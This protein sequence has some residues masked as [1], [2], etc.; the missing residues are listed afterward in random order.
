MLP[1][2]SFFDKLATAA[3]G[4][5]MSRFRQKIEIENKLDDGF[6]PVTAADKS[7][8]RA[9]RAVIEQTYPDHGILG[10]EE[11][12]KNLD[13]EFVW[14]IDPI[15]G[16]RAFITGLP[17]WGTLIG[18][19]QNGRAVMGMMDQPFTGERFLS[20][21]QSSFM[22][23]RGGEPQVL[24]TSNV[25]DL[26]KASMF[27]TTPELHTGDNS[28]RYFALENEIN[29]PRYGVDCYAYGMLAMGHADLVCES[30]LKPY[31]IGGLIAVVENAG[32]VVTRW[33][34]GRPEMGG[35]C[36]AAATPELHAK[37]LEVLNR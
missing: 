21:G 2:L 27:T 25:T 19:Y 7:A 8:E 17:V 33:D 6:D 31:D 37:A 30:D 26:S 24:K 15:D 13:S 18:L 9:I 10:E 12:N 32:G 3:A 20:D 28:R 22:K 16:T 4:E 36:L 35:D 34:G 11:D 23:L 5:T 29:L 1:D 14:V